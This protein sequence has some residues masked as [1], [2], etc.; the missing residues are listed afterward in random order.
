MVKPLGDISGRTA[1]PASVISPN[2]SILRHLSLFSSDQLLRGF[3]GQSFWT[4][5]PSAIFFVVLSIQPKHSASSTASMYQNVSSSTGLP[6]F[7]TTQHSASFLWFCM[8]HSRNSALDFAPSKLCISI[9]CYFNL[10]FTIWGSPQ[11]KKA[12]Y[13]SQN[14]SVPADWL[15]TFET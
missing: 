15:C 3:R 8:S 4:V 10:H 6:R 2:R 9:V 14:L 1:L 11:I 13:T 12:A 5:T 7:T